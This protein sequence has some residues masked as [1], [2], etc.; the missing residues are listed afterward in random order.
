[1]SNIAVYETGRHSRGVSRLSEG[2]LQRSHPTAY[3]YHDHP[4]L[5]RSVPL[6]SQIPQRFV[7]PYQSSMFVL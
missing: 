1:M 5:A 6:D 4:S 2:E 7:T 3:D